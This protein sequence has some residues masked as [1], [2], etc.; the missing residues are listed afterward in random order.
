MVIMLILSIAGIAASF[1]LVVLSILN[2]FP[3]LIA[4]PLLFLFITILIHL[5]NERHRFK[6]FRS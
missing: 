2:L 5:F 3:K 4:F 1:Y 6:G